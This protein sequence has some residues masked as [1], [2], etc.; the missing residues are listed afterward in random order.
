M[1][2]S[3]T[4]LILKLPDQYSYFLRFPQKIVPCAYH[5]WY[6]IIY[7]CSQANT[8]KDMLCFSH[9]V[10][11]WCQVDKFKNVLH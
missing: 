4:Q 3:N 7:D 10:C 11:K 2:K 9:P 8:S 1:K 6:E 5:D